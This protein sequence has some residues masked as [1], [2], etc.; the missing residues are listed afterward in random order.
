MF[1]EQNEHSFPMAREAYECAQHVLADP[2]LSPEVVAMDADRARHYAARAALARND[3]DMPIAAGSV[4]ADTAA[5]RP[6]T[7]AGR[8]AIAEALDPLVSPEQVRA[9]LTGTADTLPPPRL[10]AS[11]TLPPHVYDAIKDSLTPPEK[12]KRARKGKG[13]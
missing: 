6:P 3:F 5:A 9:I 2:S 4:A 1:A 7:L 13:E 8:V 10:H 11:D 12:P